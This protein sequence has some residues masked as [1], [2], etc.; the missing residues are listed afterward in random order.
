[1]YKLRLCRKS[2]LCVKGYMVY[3]SVTIKINTLNWF[4]TGCLL[5]WQ[6]ITSLHHFFTSLLYITSNTGKNLVK[7]INH[8]A[9]L[10]LVKKLQLLRIIE[11]GCY[12]IKLYIFQIANNYE[13]LPSS[14]IKINQDR[15]EFNR[16]MLILHVG[17]T[18]WFLP[19]PR[20]EFSTLYFPECC[21]KKNYS[22]VRFSPKWFDCGSF[23]TEL[24][25]VHI[26]VRA[27]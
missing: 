27:K 2:R 25:K 9:W 22:W 3:A 5:S 11:R 26:G 21:E 12:K 8:D 23:F 16:G 17:Y 24:R 1:M 19:I 14:L 13:Y 15:P 10:T 18:E 6:R 20:C 7:Y 4:A